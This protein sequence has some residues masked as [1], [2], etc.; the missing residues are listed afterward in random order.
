[1]LVVKQGSGVQRWLKLHSG[2]PVRIT[3]EPDQTTK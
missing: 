3:I 1:M 2:R